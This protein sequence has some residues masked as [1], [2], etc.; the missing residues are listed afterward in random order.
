ML[1]IMCFIVLPCS[2]NR[3]LAYKFEYGNKVAARGP[4][5]HGT[6]CRS[7]FRS[8]LGSGVGV[9]IARHRGRNMYPGVPESDAT[10]K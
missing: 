3:C 8:G 1:Y 9:F 5:G 10:I 2:C 6:L 7:F 4:Q